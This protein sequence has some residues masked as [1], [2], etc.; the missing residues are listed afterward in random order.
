FRDI[1]Q[2]I[3]GLDDVLAGFGYFMAAGKLDG[4]AG[5]DQIGICAEDILIHLEYFFPTRRFTKVIASD[6]PQAIA[7]AYG[8]A[9]RRKS[10]IRSLAG[11]GGLCAVSGLS[12]L[13][14]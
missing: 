6:I 12:C 11:V 14:N 5:H 3:A 2:S 8:I 7:G 10:R 13:G 1:P 9:L 4:G